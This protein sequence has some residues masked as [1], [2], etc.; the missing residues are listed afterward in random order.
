MPSWWMPASCAKALSPTIALFGGT[1]MPMQALTSREVCASCVVSICV[2]MPKKSLA[3]M[4]RHD[5]L[6]ERGVAGAL[7][8]AVD[9]AF[10]LPRARVHACQAIR[11]RHAQVV[12]AVGRDND[13]LGALAPS[14]GCQDHRAIL[15]GREIADRVG[16]V[17]RGRAGTRSPPPAPGA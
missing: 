3:R 7:A 15:V 2:S 10:D 11:D 6:F 14:C 9:R 5:D 16:D 8:D 17:Q 12:V 13:L 1:G 4:Q